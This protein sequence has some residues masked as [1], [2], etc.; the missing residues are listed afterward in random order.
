M[1]KIVSLKEI[2]DKKNHIQSRKNQY[3][4]TD[5]NT[6]DYLK[7]EFDKILSEIRKSKKGGEKDGFTK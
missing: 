2:R 1:D 4:A 5:N 3:K 6:I 7:E